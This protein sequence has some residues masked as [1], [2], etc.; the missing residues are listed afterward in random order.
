MGRDSNTQG[1]VQ[2]ASERDATWAA[3]PTARTSPSATAMAE[4]I[5][6]FSTSS[7]P[8]SAPASIATMAIAR[9]A[10]LEPAPPIA[11]IRNAAS[12]I[13]GDGLRSQPPPDSGGSEHPP[14][15]TG[16]VSP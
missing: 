16:H 4:A 1:R 11:P 13:D 9:R 2:A 14:V 3:S 8:I 15:P 10:G 6:T 12:A 7:P 5:D